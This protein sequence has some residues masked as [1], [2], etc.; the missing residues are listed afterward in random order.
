MAEE[1]II[2][3]LRDNKR[4]EFFN[5]IKVQDDSAIIYLKIKL[6]NNE[7]RAI[8]LTDGQ[9]DQLQKVYNKEIFEK[10]NKIKR[11]KGIA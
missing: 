2:D 5:S 10:Q 7:I 11:L 8:D 6:E 4:N 3:A 9:I 1:K